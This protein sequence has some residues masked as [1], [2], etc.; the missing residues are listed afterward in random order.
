MSEGQLAL[1]ACTGRQHAPET[2]ARE[3]WVI[4][5]RRAGKSIVAAL[6]AVFLEATDAQTQP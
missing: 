1:Y 2:P 5:G 6:V 3:G 4:A